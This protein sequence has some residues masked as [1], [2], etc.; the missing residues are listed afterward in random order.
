M[1]WAYH[2]AARA[3]ELSIVFLPCYPIPHP[4]VLFCVPLA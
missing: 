4:D 2:P 3:C 1:G